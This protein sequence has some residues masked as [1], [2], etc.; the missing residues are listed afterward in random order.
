MI[1]A[2]EVNRH[3]NLLLRRYIYDILI[4]SNVD[5]S[6]FT[7]R[8]LDG[9][10]ES[11]EVRS[12]MVPL[13]GCLKRGQFVSHERLLEQ[14]RA[15]LFKPNCGLGKLSCYRLSSLMHSTP[16]VIIDLLIR[17]G[18]ITPDNESNFMK[19]INRLHGSFDY[20]KW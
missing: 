19:V 12:S 11:F 13:H 20:A 4:P 9:E 2:L 17:L 18:Y 15:G 14:L 7:P 5:P 1:S 8:P 16:T 10:V 6:P 3:V